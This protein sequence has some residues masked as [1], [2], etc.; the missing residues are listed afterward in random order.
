MLR[1]IVL[2]MFVI[3]VTFG[4]P[5]R[6][7]SIEMAEK[8]GVGAML[9]VIE[10]AAHNLQERDWGGLGATNGDIREHTAAAERAAL[11]TAQAATQAA[12]AEAARLRNAMIAEM[13]T[14]RTSI[15]SSDV[16]DVE[17]E[18]HSTPLNG[19]GVTVSAS[20]DASALARA[21]AAT[22]A[23]QAAQAAAE[24]ATAK[25]QRQLETVREA[26]AQ[27]YSAQEKELEE[28]RSRL[29]DVEPRGVEQHYAASA[30]ATPAVRASTAATPSTSVD[31]EERAVQVEALERAVAALEE[32]REELRRTAQAAARREARRAETAE[33]MAQE[34]S[35]LQA[36]FMG[37]DPPGP[38][39]LRISRERT[40][41]LEEMVELRS[42]L[43]R[44][45]QEAQWQQEVAD[46]VRRRAKAADRRWSGLGM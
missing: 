7:Q 14:R 9:A 5:R 3:V 34:L 22:A 18:M 28:L 17:D 4:G 20:P 44:A 33:L 16:D 10:R 30:P 41:A 25:L 27:T 35:E 43:E 21:E 6:R 12:E 38:A 42:Q 15:A 31:E 19:G 13:Q 45:Q 26:A 46:R 11:A 40:A 29:R 37:G 36:V 8:T 32:E 2:P 23:A 24:Q 39:L 1:Y